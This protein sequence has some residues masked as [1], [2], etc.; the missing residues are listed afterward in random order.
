MTDYQYDE[1]SAA[2]LL[3]NTTGMITQEVM[4]QRDVSGRQFASGVQDFVWS[5]ARPNC[6]VPSMSYFLLDVTLKGGQDPSIAVQPKIWEQ[7]ALAENIGHSLYVSSYFNMGGNTVSSC[8]QFHA[9]IG[10]LHERVNNSAAWARSIG[11][12]VY[13]NS[14]SFSERCAAISRNAEATNTSVGI[15]LTDGKEEFYRPG[16]TESKVA[17][18]VLGALTG[19]LTTFSAAD[20]GNSIIVDGFKFQIKSVSNATTATVTPA[21]TTAL[22]DPTAHWYMVRRNETRTTQARNA[23]QLIWR[24]PLGIWGTT[25]LLGAGQY[26]ISLSPDSNYQFSAVECKQVDAHLKTPGV[27]VASPYTLTINNVR[28]Y[29]TTCQYELPDGP[30]APLHLLEYAGYA[31]T[32]SGSQ[33]SFN[34]SVPPSTEQLFVFVQA[35]SAGS[36]PVY[37]PSKFVAVNNSDLN[38]ANVQLTYAGQTKPPT[39]LQAGFNKSMVG[40]DVSYL[41]QMYYQGILETGRNNDTGGTESLDDYLQRGPFYAFTFDKD[42]SS[43]ETEVAIQ[44]GYNNPDSAQFDPG[45]KLFLV[46]R[47]RTIREVTVSQG[48]IT[49]V[50]GL[51]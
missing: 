19:T 1:K 36:N 10:A 35:P 49:K 26:K 22:S 27:G 46:A 17:I 39:R 16:G 9:Q 24:P 41:T 38:L 40:S 51:N 47:Y 44:I 8:N 11:V 43:M 6:W 7:L 3:H 4:C 21:P 45:T 48:M 23:L 25:N 30:Q 29:P 12:G 31:R 50:V 34:F 33:A 14:A 18:S 32:M 42:A 15:S 5:V 37:P 20:V 28:F 13:N 2:A